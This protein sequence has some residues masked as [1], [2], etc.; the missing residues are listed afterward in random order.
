M[1]NAMRIV[2]VAV[3]AG[4]VILFLWDGVLEKLPPMKRQ[5]T[6]MA[7]PPSP[8]APPPSPLDP[9][10]TPRPSH[11]QAPAVILAGLASLVTQGLNLGIRRPDILEPHGVAVRVCPDGFL[12]QVNIHSAGQGIG[13]HQRGRC[14][15]AGLDQRA[16][17]SF[18][19]SIA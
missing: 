3:L 14:Q 12:G 8:L 17:A 1:S 10:P 2:I 13:H 7:P 5:Q 4:L 9:P 6:P 16:D 15:I 19:V 11:R 18:K